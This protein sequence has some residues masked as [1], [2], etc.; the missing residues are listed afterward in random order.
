MLPTIPTIFA[1]DLDSSEEGIE[2]SVKEVSNEIRRRT[3]QYCKKDENEFYEIPIILR[4]QYR[5]CANLTI[6][7]MPGVSYSLQTKHIPLNSPLFHS[8]SYKGMKSA[9][10]RFVRWPKTKC[11]PKIE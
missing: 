6:I 9:P 2:V 3:L 11:R 7:D 5:Y 10:K 8:L 1:D 4:V